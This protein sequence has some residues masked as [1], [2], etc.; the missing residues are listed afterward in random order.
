MGM[1]RWYYR[2]NGVNFMPDSGNCGD[3]DS[4]HVSTAGVVMTATAVTDSILR[5]RDCE[6]AMKNYYVMTA[7]S[8]N[9]KHSY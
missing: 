4:I 6:N 2:G 7:Y 8:S 1:G 5:R 3:G 9:V